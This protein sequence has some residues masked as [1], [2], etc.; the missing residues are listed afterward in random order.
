VLGAVALALSAVLTG[1]LPYVVGQ[2]LTGPLGVSDKSGFFVPA[3]T[4]PSG[5][6]L[7]ALLSDRLRSTRRLSR[8]FLVGV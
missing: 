5:A 2:M 3:V 8:W 6:I 4:I 7:C 1:V